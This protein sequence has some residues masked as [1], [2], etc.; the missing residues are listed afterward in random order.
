M[1]KIIIVLLM[2]GYCDFL[3][4][5]SWKAVDTTN[6]QITNEKASS[7]SSG[8]QNRP[9]STLVKHKPMR[10]KEGS[11]IQ[12]AKKTTGAIAK[13]AKKTVD[14]IT[15]KSVNILNETDK[16][17]TLKITAKVDY[18]VYIQI[19]DEHFNLLAAGVFQEDESNGKSVWTT[20]LDPKH[21]AGKLFIV[22][23]DASRILDT[24]TTN[25]KV[26]ISTNAKDV[27][28]IDAKENRGYIRLTLES[29]RID[30]KPSLQLSS[31][32]HHLPGHHDTSSGDIHKATEEEIK[33]S[34]PFILKPL[35][36]APLSK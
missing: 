34:R 28:K 7:K 27:F 31:I 9:P 20:T 35:R 17:G 30:N 21:I 33:T 26:F 10:A 13:T 23:H 18:S 1:K 29:I 4:L 3:L 22:I 16:L 19:G 24:Q 36:P 6:I 32:H 11:L 8:P 15:E 25:E 14:Y 12:T 2:V 5:S